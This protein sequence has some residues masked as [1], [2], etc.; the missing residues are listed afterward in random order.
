[1]KQTKRTRRGGVT[2]TRTTRRIK[3]EPVRRL[4]PEEQEATARAVAKFKMVNALSVWVEVA[5]RS[6]QLPEH[7]RFEGRGASCSV[8]GDVSE[9]TTWPRLRQLGATFGY[10]EWRATYCRRH[11]ECGK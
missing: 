5:N 9:F 1:M 10:W 3:L 6:T 2:R 7:V 11:A 4:D 8:C